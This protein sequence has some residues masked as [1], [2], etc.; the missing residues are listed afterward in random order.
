MIPLL[1]TGKAKEKIEKIM[2]LKYET[3]QNLPAEAPEPLFSTKSLYQ[4]IIPLIIEQFL[5]VF[6]GMVDIMMISSSGEAAVS[7]I[8][9]VDTINVLLIN[10]FSAL[11]TGGAV[12]SAHYL[13][14]NKPEKACLS[15]NQL[16]LSVAVL[17]S[18]IA[19]ITLLFNR[20]LLSLIFG[21]VEESVMES[22]VIYFYLSSLSYPFL[23]VYNGCAALCR[24]MGNSKI[25]M[26][27]SLCMNLINITGNSIFLYLFQMGVAGVGT[28]TLISRITAAIMMCVIILNKRNT[29]H[30]DLSIGFAPKFSVI[31]DILKVGI[32]TGLENS[33]FQLGKI[34]V[35]SLIASFGTAAIAANAVANTIAS[36]EIIPAS[37][38]GLA[39]VTVTGQAYGAKRKEETIYYV[40]RLMKMAYGSITVT[41]LLTCA[42]SSAI[43]QFYSL[44]EEAS[45]IALSII[46]YHSVACIIIW[47]ASFALPNALRASDNAKY[48]MVVS[49]CSMWIC[50]IGFSYLIGGAMG[51]GAL[52][53]W[54]AMSIDWM[55]RSICFLWKFRNGK[56]LAKMYG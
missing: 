12:V 20:Q 34:L 42:A 32:P 35:Q 21:H 48:T 25:S 41:S 3:S 52:G 30:V 55:V 4:L 37:A 16:I 50:R 26:K 8:S 51:F 14:Q 56:W 24:S 47:P 27:T 28:A 1:F 29:I 11:A 44:S 23:G 22:A 46:L 39:L 40:K 13:G 38:I 2:S 6:V 45:A 7:G 36:F 17:S 15:A 43:I 19:V 9:L 53:V 5:S 10:L 18:T 31:A 33:I 54:I 49:I